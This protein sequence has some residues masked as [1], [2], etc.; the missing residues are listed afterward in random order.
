MASSH[1]LYLAYGSHFL[2]EVQDRQWNNG[3]IRGVMQLLP[4]IVAKIV[5]LEDSFLLLDLLLEISLH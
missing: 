3:P 4:C 5:K 2:Q 1:W